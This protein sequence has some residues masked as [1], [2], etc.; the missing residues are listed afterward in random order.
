MAGFPFECYAASY[1]VLTYTWPLTVTVPYN[2]FVKLE[3][4]K[5]TTKHA[6]STEYFVLWMAVAFGRTG[7]PP[8]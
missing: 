8:G 7:L 4:V 6:S 3:I 2:K 5:A 1:G